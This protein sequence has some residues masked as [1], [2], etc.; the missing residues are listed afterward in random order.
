MRGAGVELTRTTIVFV[1]SNSDAL[2]SIAVRIL[3]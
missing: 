1:L 3:R 2:L